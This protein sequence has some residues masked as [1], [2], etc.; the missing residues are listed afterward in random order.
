[1]RVRVTT[2]EI[3][4]LLEVLFFVDYLFKFFI[5]ERN[6]SAF[7]LLEIFVEQIYDVHAARYEIAGTKTTSFLRLYYKVSC[8]T[9]RMILLNTSFCLYGY[10]RINF[11]QISKQLSNDMKGCQNKRNKEEICNVTKTIWKIN[12]RGRGSE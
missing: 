10:C 3:V 12:K 11:K 7:A 4:C 5:F 8:H 9:C 2:M 6:S 1:M